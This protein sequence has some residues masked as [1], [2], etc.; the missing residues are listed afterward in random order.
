MLEKVAGICLVDKLRSIQLYEADLNWFMK[1]I[2][3]DIAIEKMK[4]VNLLPEEHYSQKGSTA[5]DACFEKTLTLDISRQ[6]R[7]P[8][9][10]IS[11]NAAQCYDRVHPTLMSLIWLGLTNHP[12]SV[13]LLLHVLQQMK[14]YTR[15]GFGDSSTFFGGEDST[16]LCGLVVTRGRYI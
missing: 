10:L 11:V 8:M 9:A 12:Q 16:P 6:S 5:E 15:T 2:F 3:H 14:I 1:F 13:I 4:N 7:T